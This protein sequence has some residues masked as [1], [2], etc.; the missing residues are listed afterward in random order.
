MADIKVDI[1]RLRTAGIK[2]A[3]TARSLQTCYRE[4]E[5][6]RSRVRYKVAAQQQIDRNLRITL[7]QIN[8]EYRR[9]VNGNWSWNDQRNDPGRDFKYFAGKTGYICEYED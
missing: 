7:Q 3:Q 8:T 4:V 5:S 9:N 2:E 6:I 1:R